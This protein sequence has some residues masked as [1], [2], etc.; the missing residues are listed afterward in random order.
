M[1]MVFYGRYFLIYPEKV[2]QNIPVTSS[3][4]MAAI[5]GDL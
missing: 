4:R 2:P 5:A 3:P 1:W